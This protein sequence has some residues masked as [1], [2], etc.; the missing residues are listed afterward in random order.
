MQ[1]RGMEVH[2]DLNGFAEFNAMA[3][4]AGFHYADSELHSLTLC[5]CNPSNP[6][7]LTVNTRDGNGFS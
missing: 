4:I 7:S 5:F 2:L 6:D 3:G 1:F